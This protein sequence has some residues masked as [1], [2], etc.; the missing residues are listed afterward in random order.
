MLGSQNICEVQNK[1]K[2]VGGVL[3]DAYQS[4]LRECD[5]LEFF[6]AGKVGNL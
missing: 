3:D 2:D 4:Q 6:G 5:G 1:S